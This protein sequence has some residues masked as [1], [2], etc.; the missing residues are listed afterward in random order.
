MII[1]ILGL[2]SCGISIVPYLGSVISL[3]ITGPFAL[4]LAI[5]FLKLVRGEEVNVEL[6]FEGFKDFTRSFIAGVLV[7]I[8]IGLWCLLL[9]IPGIIAS[10]AYS[11]TFFILADNH[12]LT[13]NEAIK[14]SKELMQ[15]HKTE[16]FML[17]LSFIG[18][19]LLGILS[20]GIGFLWISSYIYT[21]R[22]IFY[23]EIKGEAI[24][25][26]VA[27]VAFEEVVNE[28]LKEE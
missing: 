10:Y 2:I 26:P 19:I 9:I 6:M 4:G 14:A 12:N 13:A 22:A 11:M 5:V 27:D 17:D 18:W 3:L 21:A 16:L 7:Y 20:C 1:L 15:G 24:A 25:E 28:P 8:Y 23:H